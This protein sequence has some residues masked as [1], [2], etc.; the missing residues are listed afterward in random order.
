MA[1][2]KRRFYSDAH[3]LA[4]PYG[5][6]AIPVSTTKTGHTIVDRVIIVQ[7]TRIKPD[8]QKSHYMHRPTTN[9]HP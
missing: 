1:F 4:S 7:N 9:Q 3:Q 2:V 6:R 8:S 5:T